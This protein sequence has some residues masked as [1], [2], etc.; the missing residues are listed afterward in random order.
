MAVCIE[1]NLALE[2]FG[3]AI[4]RIEHWNEWNPIVRAMLVDS[5]SECACRVVTKESA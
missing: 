2:P 5:N 4:H 1:E 3:E